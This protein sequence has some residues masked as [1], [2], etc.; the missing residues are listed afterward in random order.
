MRDTM[1]GCLAIV[2]AILV[3]CFF[4]HVLRFVAITGELRGVC[5]GIAGYMG[6]V[7][8]ASPRRHGRKR[9]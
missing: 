7:R 1:R 3:A 2:V 5:A 4:L 8:I 9:T 6:G